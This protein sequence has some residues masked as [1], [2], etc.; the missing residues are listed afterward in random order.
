MNAVME[1]FSYSGKEVQFWSI[2]GK[3]V[4]SSKRSETH[5]NTSY[6]TARTSSGI[7]YSVPRVNSDVVV[8]QEFFLLTEDGKE[9]PIQ[10]TGYDVPVRD[11]HTVTMIG[12]QVPGKGDYWVRM[13]VHDTGQSW[14]VNNDVQLPHMWGLVSGNRRV[15]ILLGL[16]VVGL[17]LVLPTFGASLLVPVV[18][19]ISS[20][21]RSNALIRRLKQHMDRL[22]RTA[23]AVKP[24]LIA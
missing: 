15:L 19:F 7:T 4:S 16:I 10:L 18:Y 14:A 24:S 22:S 11:G 17:I 2:T 12:G 9:V 13:A 8:K 23:L 1:P 5:V 20:A 6:G 3:V 21:R